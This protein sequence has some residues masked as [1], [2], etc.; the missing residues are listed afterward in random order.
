MTAAQMGTSVLARVEGRVGHLT[1]NRPSA[2]NALD[3]PM[4]TAVGAA[5]AG[6]E[7]DPAVAAVLLD[8]AG[9]RGLCA[10]ADVRA[11]RSAVLDG[12]AARAL[13]FLRQ[14][15]RLN[16]R[17]AEY[18]K[19][20]LAVMDGIT[21]G[22]GVGLSAHA[23][24]RVV[25]ERSRVAMPETRIGFV[26]DVGGSH[27]LARAPGLTG[28]HLGVTAAVAGPGDAIYTGLADHFVPAE[29]LPALTAAV[30]ED[31]D[32]AGAV[33]ALAVAP[34]AG[35]LVG[36]RAWIDECYDAPTALAV[37]RR[38]AA[39]PHPAARGTAEVIRSLS[40]TAVEVAL[41]T[42]TRARGGTLRE[43]LQQELRSGAGLAARAD[44]TEGIRAQL[45][46]KDRRPRWDPPTL[47]KVDPAVVAAVLDTDVPPLF[48][49]PEPP[50]TA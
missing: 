37:V 11:L 30:L 4:L 16:A 36:H 34:P 22:G 48:P 33:R 6:W 12:E 14:E 25:T 23:S 5:L 49:A 3:A 43:A 47:E 19:P 39:H 45:V 50:R 20:V 8:G 32:P 7:H 42:L 10:G 15:Y 35:E 28:V 1:L 29:S 2:I 40:P 21:M 41:A 13:D 31:G 9:D 18:P 44:F 17:I 38:L 26:P 46:D 27:L 24:L